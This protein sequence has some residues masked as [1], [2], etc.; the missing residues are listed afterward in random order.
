MKRQWLYIG[1]AIASILQ[2]FVKMLWV[3]IIFKNSNADLHSIQRNSPELFFIFL[4]N[5]AFAFVV[6]FFYLHVPNEKRNI[7]TGATIG[8]I[9]GLLIGFYQYIGWYGSF[10]I[11]VTFIIIEIFRTI[12]LAVM[13]GVTISFIELKTNRR[14][15]SDPV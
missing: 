7:K 11:S 8:G 6:G 2:F 14:I 13:C 4:S 5:V 9:L 10:N 15:K 3:E 12:I 1:V